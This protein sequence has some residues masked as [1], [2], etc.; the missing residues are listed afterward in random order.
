LVGTKHTMEKRVT[1]KE[2]NGKMYKKQ[3]I[4]NDK[5]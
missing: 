2:I 1:T 4:L 5:T 3:N